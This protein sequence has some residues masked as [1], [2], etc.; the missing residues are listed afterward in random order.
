VPAGSRLTSERSSWKTALLAGIV[1]GLAAHIRPMYQLY[2]PILSIVVFVEERSI[3]TAFKRFLIIVAGFS[4]IVLPWS[5]YMTT[6]FDRVIV[7]TSNGG[8]T[9]SGGLTPKLLEPT[10]ITTITGGGRT[11]WVGP[12][13][14]VTLD[15][16][17]YL[18]AKEL[19][20][21]YDQLDSLLRER[22]IKW[23]SENPGKA[24][25]LEFYKLAYMWGV[26]SPVPNGLSQ[27]LFGSIPAA[28]LLLFSIACVLFRPDD[29]VQLVRLWTLALFVSGIALISWGSWRF[30]QPADAGLLAF[31]VICLAHI[32][33]SRFGSRN[34][35]TKT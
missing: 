6:R 10:G 29:R 21:P 11:A 31:S 7:L 25:Q 3:P 26:Y 19:T 2:L 33:A 28:M 16:S 18:S 4:L 15:Q 17:G 9:L 20:L 27:T 8:E 13:K 30:R 5:A 22:T 34:A 24:L 14:W 12:G 1:L 35:K 23:I 32:I